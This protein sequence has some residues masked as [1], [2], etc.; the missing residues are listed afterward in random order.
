MALSTEFPEALFGSEDDRLEQ[1]LDIDNYNRASGYDV[2]GY[3]PVFDELRHVALRV[4]GRLPADLRGVYI[5][6]GANPQFA[7]KRSRLHPFN[8]PGMLHQVEIQDGQVSYSNCYL[9]TPRYAVEARVGRE[10]YAAFSDHAGGGKAGLARMQWVEAKK[11]KG[12]LP[13]L[14]PMEMTTASTSVQC[15]DDTLYC[16]NETAY[17]FALKAVRENGRLLLDGNG[18]LETWDGRLQS[19][20]SAHPRI[21]PNTG[22][23]YNVS[24]DRLKGGV[25]YSRLE[26][27]RLVD[28]RLIHQQ[29]LAK[30]TM[31]FLHD[32]IVTDRFLVFPDTSLRNRRER[33][34]GASG[35]PY[36]FDHG[37]KM[38]WGVLPRD[39]ADGD[40]VRWF[41]TA[42]AGFLWHMVN[43]WE[44][45]TADGH[46][47]IV[48]YAPM[49]DDYPSDIPVHSP[50]EPHAKLHK[51]VLD[52][53]TGEV[54]VDRQLLAHPYERPSINT[55]FSG[56]RSRYT[57]LLDES[58]GYMGCG[59]LKYD[60]V[61][62]ASQAYLSYGD[63]VGG[64]AL[65]VTRAGATDEDDGYLVDLLMKDNAADLVVIDART[66]TELARIHLPRRVPYGV[67]SC[68]LDAAQVAALVAEPSA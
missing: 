66:M 43:G 41:D 47:G 51:W 33:I 12:L 31:A 20:F 1:A 32:Y 14:S 50:R 28:H 7:V 22:T 54:V 65:F 56:R 60:L 17:P 38:R 59:V 64:E 49:F 9:R 24:I 40:V 62:E 3:R 26:R 8:G 21:D 48:L 42:Q 44:E 13:N 11:Q 61:E 55:A 35:S 52:L 45:T 5:R 27:G 67:H 63:A 15:H 23:F 39:P 19:P 29:D 25:H 4:T 10:A 58:G 6:N 53:D 46:A 57:Y 36:H 68:W 18:H 16:F 30:G 37:Y 2:P 34:M